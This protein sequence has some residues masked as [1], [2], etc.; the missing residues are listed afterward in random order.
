MQVYRFIVIAGASQIQC[1]VCKE[2]KRPGCWKRPHP[3]L[4][5][6]LKYSWFTSSSSTHLFGSCCHSQ[7]LPLLLPKLLQAQRRFWIWGRKI[8]D[9]RSR[10]KIS[11][12]NRSCRGI[13]KWTD[14]PS[15]R[16]TRPFRPLSV[17]KLWTGGDE[18]DK[19]MGQKIRFG[20]EKWR[21]LEKSDSEGGIKMEKRGGKAV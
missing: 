11:A 19:Q 2:N 9:H 6:P 15:T 17:W 14:S 5:L 1:R 12:L 3:P 21:Q 4:S 13:R 10:L 20:E 18:K 16:K 7:P 8:A